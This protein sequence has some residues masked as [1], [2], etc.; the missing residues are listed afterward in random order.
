MLKSINKLFYFKVIKKIILLKN[1]NLLLLNLNC[2][3]YEI[4]L[5]LNVHIIIF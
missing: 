4:I 1:I 5:K 3:F 2:K